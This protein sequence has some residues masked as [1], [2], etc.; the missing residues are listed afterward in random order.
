MN[1][2]LTFSKLKLVD[3][4]ILLDLSYGLKPLSMRAKSYK[5][6]A[7]EVSYKA[8]V[9]RKTRLKCYILKIVIMG[10]RNS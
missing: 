5:T 9:S 1:A 3:N 10:T 7:K 2:L 8:P 4:S 6:D